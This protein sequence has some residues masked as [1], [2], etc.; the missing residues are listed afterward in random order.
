MKWPGQ[1]ALWAT[2]ALL[3]LGGLG[4]V[5]QRQSQEVKRRV[6]VQVAGRPASGSAVFKSKGC[7]GCHGAQAA[8]SE[9]GPSLHNR[10]SFTSLAQL[11]TAMWNHAP[12][13][14]Q[15][16]E[17]QHRPY[18][19]LNYTETTQLVTYL[20]M[21]GYADDGGD[22]ERGARLFSE[23]K[24]AQC[25][26][27]R[28]NGK[29]PALSQMSDAEDPLAWTQSLW[30]HAAAMQARMQS[31]GVAWPRLQASD[32][33]DL[34]AYVK[35]AR[36]LP[37]DGWPDISGDP[38]RGWQVFQSKGCLQCH[39]L[40]A[41]DKSLAPS[42]GAERQLPP[43][44]SEFGAAMLNHFPSMESAMQSQKTA[45][46]R[47]ENHD[48]ADIAVFLYSLHFL[49]PSGSLQVG[50]S[51]FAWRGCSACHG[52]NAEGSGSGPALR[53]RGQAYTAV[54]LATALWAHG[55]TMYQSARQQHQTW[56]ELEDSDIGHLLTFL[57]TSPEM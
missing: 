43:T 16:M 48:V 49:E 24:C 3:S 32:M 53:G 35:Q 47:F 23:R 2:A 39:A 44:F 56:P 31:S 17:S 15:E 22:A 41:Q 12:R 51:V 34:F 5:M 30:N 54:R 40:S 1:L 52:D 46:P 29:G 38:D 57:N 21:S 4:L 36:S 25:H 14:W 9:S 50:R 20:Y 26:D 13:M 45:L 55:G 37:D 10:R 27:Q 33:R 19:T 7:A 28:G 8:G 11:V 42:L 6:A 18:P